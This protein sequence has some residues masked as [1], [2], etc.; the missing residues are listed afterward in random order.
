[1]V[2]GN[3]QPYSHSMT[4]PNHLHPHGA[5]VTAS[6]QATI[7]TIFFTSDFLH[8]ILLDSTSVL[9]EEQSSSTPFHKSSPPSA[10]SFYLHLPPP[11]KHPRDCHH[12]HEKLLAF[13]SCP[14]KV[15]FC[16]NFSLYKCHL[17]PP[18]IFPHI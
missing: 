14:H 2:E 11:M 10:A 5:L 9:T 8:V 18:H 4:A 13:F 15:N 12:I 6:H 3:F 17:P 1:M 16:L 7:Q